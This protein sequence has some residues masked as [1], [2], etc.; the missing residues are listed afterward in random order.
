MEEALKRPS[1]R[2][3]PLTLFSRADPAELR[4]V[5]D[6]VKVRGRMWVE[7]SS[8]YPGQVDVKTDYSFVYPFVQA[9]PGAE[10]VER[11]V[12]R[13]EATFA[14]A[15]PRLWRA[16]P[17]MLRLVE[18]RSD[19]ANYDCGRKDGFLHPVFGPDTPG[20]PTPSGTP[21]DPYDRGRAIADVGPDGCWSISRS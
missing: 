3:D 17:G 15:D 19:Y 11:T 1:A 13:R 8:R 16:T 10:Q 21:M 2:N 9:K 7:A 4:L 18:F 5:G 6:V 12:V 20:G 14:I